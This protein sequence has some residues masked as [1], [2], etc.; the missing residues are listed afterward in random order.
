MT[1]LPATV[2]LVTA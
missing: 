1:Y 2:C